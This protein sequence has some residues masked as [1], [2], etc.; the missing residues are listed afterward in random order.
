MRPS[1][2]W[3]QPAGGKERRKNIENDDVDE[4]AKG[5]VGTEVEFGAVSSHGA[6]RTPIGPK[7][8]KRYASMDPIRR[9][10]VRGRVLRKGHAVDGGVSARK[11]R[12]YIPK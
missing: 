4:P 11:T 5:Y 10:N 9:C 2:T 7:M 3:I 8:K 6:H 12:K 1:F